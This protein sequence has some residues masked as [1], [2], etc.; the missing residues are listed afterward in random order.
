MTR[1]GAKIEMES[2][3][4][5]V[6]KLSNPVE[7]VFFREFMILRISVSDETLYIYAHPKHMCEADYHI[8]KASFTCTYYY[9]QNS[10][11]A[12]IIIWIAMNIF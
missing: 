12:H 7:F 6:E 4:N 1:V 3:I 11:L 8:L 9:G 2:L 10:L 5:L